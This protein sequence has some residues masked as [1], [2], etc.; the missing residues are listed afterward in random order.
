MMD[1]D[2]YCDYFHDGSII[3]IHHKNNK[4]E[5]LMESA[6][7]DPDIAS[8]I[9]LSEHD[10]LAGILHIEEIKKIR[11][12]SINQSI[13]KKTFDIGDIC[14]FEIRDKMVRLVIRWI[15][16]PPKQFEETKPFVIEIEAG[17]IYWENIPNLFDCAQNRE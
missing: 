7:I 12:D 16:F 5:I 17:N 9:A 6:E 14:T 15:N 10:I 13:L 11:I 3:T 4:I 2:K 8:D 1:I